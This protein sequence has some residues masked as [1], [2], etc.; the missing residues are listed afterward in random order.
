MQRSLYNYR[1]VFAFIFMG[2]SVFVI[3][4]VTIKLFLSGELSLGLKNTVYLL[5]K[6]NEL[7]YQFLV[8]MNFIFKPIFIYYLTLVIFYIYNKKTKAFD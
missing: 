6:T 5:W 1:H 2:M 7:F 4:I 8:V 3:K